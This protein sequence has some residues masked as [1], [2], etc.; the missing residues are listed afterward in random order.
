MA[1]RFVFAHASEGAP[2]SGQDRAGATAGDDN[3]LV[4]L[5]DGAGGTG[6]GEM[7][8][9][10]VVEA[11]LYGDPSDS[12]WVDE[13]AMFDDE[14][15]ER[16]AQATSVIVEVS[17]D[18]IR[19]ASVGD[20]GAWLVRGAEIDDLT[21]DQRR[22]PL[23]GAGAEVVAFERGPLAGG[24]LI[25]ASDGLFRY[26]KAADIARAATGPDLDAAARAMIELVRLPTGELQDD[27]SIVLV[28]ER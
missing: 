2:G 28:R 26:A 11:V 20:S 12:G 6:D 5:S 14:L 10:L 4:V 25:V 27:V 7:A 1:E 13:L 17:A 15:A 16:G 23:L 3:V 24:T 18:R 8:A 9:E 19:G 22:K 21:A